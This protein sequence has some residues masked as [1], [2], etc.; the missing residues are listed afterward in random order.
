MLFNAVHYY[1]GEGEQRT[2]VAWRWTFSRWTGS[3]RCGAPQGAPARPDSGHPLRRAGRS[4]YVTVATPARRYG[5]LNQLTVT[6][7]IAE[8]DEARRVEGRDPEAR[9]R[10]GGQ[11]RDAGERLSGTCK[12]R[13]GSPMA[14]QWIRLICTVNNYNYRRAR[15]VRS[16]GTTTVRSKN[17]THKLSTCEQRATENRLFFETYKQMMQFDPLDRPDS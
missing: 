1:T 17:D 4:P 15:N 8:L 11:L 9:P 2:D 7:R 6:T 14:S 3:P 12:S 13:P 10:R 16:C 5:H